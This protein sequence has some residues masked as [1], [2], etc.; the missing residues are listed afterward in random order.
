[1]AWPVLLLARELGF[2]GSVRQIAEIAQTLDRSRFEP[3]VGCL[4]PQGVRSAEILASGVPIAAFP[5]HSLL[6]FQALQQA[7]GLAGYVRR[8][9]IRLVHAFDYPTAVLAVPAARLATRAAVLA[10]GRS[11]CS[12]IPARL[13]R[14]VQIADRMA[15]AVLVNCQYMGRHMELEEGVPQARI[16]L[17]YN[18][19][20]LEKFQP[21]G[22]PRD[23]LTIGAVGE[24]TPEKRWDTLIEAF[25]RVRRPGLRLLLVGDGPL[26]GQLHAQAE[27][28]D[29]A[30]DLTFVPANEN[31]AAWLRA[32]DIFVLPS[33]SEAL[34]NPLLEAM[35]CGCCPV[36]SRVGGN[37]ELVRHGENGMLFEAG[38]A[39]ELS[40]VLETL[41][42]LRVL[43][44]QLAARARSTAQRFSTVQS[45]RRLEEI[46]AELI[47]STSARVSSR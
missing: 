29:A 47:E 14:V 32:I 10:S 21:L 30:R 3:H 45:V 22:T 7:A 12:L 36:A 42:E 5:V 39:G 19:V 15:N 34:S 37:P 6:S 24:L 9:G 1:M 17:C 2:A 11:H 43:R 20:D 28:L 25:A 8:H 18:G 4:R 27:Q 23:S 41:L 16:R 26:L 13:R 33:Q 31:V 35:A 46:Y 44:E 40:R 38:H